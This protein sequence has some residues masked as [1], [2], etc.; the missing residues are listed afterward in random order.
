VDEDVG[1]EGAI[2]YDYKCNAWARNAGVPGE[3]RDSTQP[4]RH[5][6][7]SALVEANVPG[8]AGLKNLSS[9]RSS[10]PQ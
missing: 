8:S 10:S 6:S 3:V 4:L 1:R 5:P 7:V 2:K 9:L